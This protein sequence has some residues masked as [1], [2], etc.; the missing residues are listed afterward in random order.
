MN[1]NDLDGSKIVYLSSKVNDDYNSSKMA[2]YGLIF[3]FTVFGINQC[4]EKY[5][6]TPS[7]SKRIKNSQVIQQSK[8]MNEFYKK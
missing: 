4:A 7:E 5:L 3:M 8:Q 2:T 1:I 6:S